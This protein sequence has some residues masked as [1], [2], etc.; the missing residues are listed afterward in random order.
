V[1]RN[2]CEAWRVPPQP[3]GV[4]MAFSDGEHRNCVCERDIGH[5]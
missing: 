2:S 1:A 5:P 3:F 4:K